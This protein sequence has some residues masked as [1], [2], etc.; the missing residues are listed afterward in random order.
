MTSKIQDWKKRIDHITQE[1]TERFQ[2]APIAEL[3]QNP[4]AESWSVTENLQHLMVVNESYFVL[5]DQL[6][7]GTYKPP[8]I[9]RIPLLANLMGKLLLKSVAPSRNKKI[10]TFLIW[11]PKEGKLQGDIL[12]QFTKQQDALKNWVEKLEPQL[13]KGLVI[14]SPASNS[15]VYTL[16]KA[17]EIIVTHEQRHLNQSIEASD[18]V[19]DNKK[20]ED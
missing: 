2:D 15:I 16:E 20:V 14:A 11:E 19:F 3:H 8:F 6:G 12:K 18:I 17:I 1:F 4:H 13:S 5:F 7:K 9:A 10:K